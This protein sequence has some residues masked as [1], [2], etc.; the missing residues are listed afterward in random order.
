MNTEIENLKFEELLKKFPYAGDFFDV[1]GLPVPDHSCQIKDYIS[2]MPYVLMED[3]GVDKN[4]LLKSLKSFLKRMEDIRSNGELFIDSI[5][6]LGGTDKNGEKEDADLRIVKGDIVSIVGPTGSGKSRLLSDIEWM[7]QGDTPTKRK[8]LIN[9]KIPPKKWRFS[10]EHKL[11]AQLSQNMNF[12]MDISVCDFITLH[13]QSRLVNNP[14]EKVKEII[15]HANALSGEAF[16]LSTPL[17][18]L[19]GG[20]SRAL[21]VADTAFLSTS[22]IVLID[23]IE[24]A[25]IDRRL[26]LDLLVG[27]D[28]IVLIATHDPLLALL[29]NRRIIIKNGGINKVIDTSPEEKAR[30]QYLEELDKSFLRY[31]GLLRNGEML[32]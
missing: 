8:I 31:R 27:Q 11:V 24:N 18:A 26:A 7:A 30:L 6:I 9:D 28:K 21:M 12:V 3:M 2:D 17:T 23:E 15:S 32:I 20:Q 1:N 5:T 22:P 29:G 16:D 14:V 25:G 13:A 10:I 4:G 19:S